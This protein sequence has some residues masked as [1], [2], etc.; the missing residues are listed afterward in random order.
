MEP[1]RQLAGEA[2]IDPH[3]TAG[4]PGTNVSRYSQAEAS[5]VVR[6]HKRGLFGNLQLHQRKKAHEENM[7]KRDHKKRH[8]SEIGD[9]ESEGQRDPS[10]HLGTGVLSALLALYD[11]QKTGT[12][13]PSSRMSADSERPN[14][15]VDVDLMPPPSAIPRPS[16]SSRTGART[17]TFWPE[18]RRPLERNGAGVFGALVASTGNISGAAAP[19]SAGLAPN[20][21]R[22]GYHLSRLELVYSSLSTNFLLLTRLDIPLRVICRKAER[23]ITQRL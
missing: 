17:P 11:N 13:T 9:V 16:K 14:L 6:A 22:P 23:S 7:E 21:K 20:L 15:Q 2:Y 1:T 12:A 18:S 8:S 10:P 4:L 5:K 3:E 19:A